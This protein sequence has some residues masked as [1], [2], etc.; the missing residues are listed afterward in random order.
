MPQAHVSTDTSVANVDNMDI[1]KKTALSR[2]DMVYGMHSKYLRYNLWDDEEK[3]VLVP[4]IP[5][6]LA[7]WTKITKP[8]PAVPRSEFRNVEAMKTIKDNPNLFK[9]VTPVNVDRFERL[10]V[11]HSNCAF[12]ELV[13]R[14]LHE[15]FWPWADMQ[16][17][18]YPCMVDESLGMPQREKEG[19]FL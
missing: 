17:G 6:D 1:T 2:I 14:G 5:L 16:Y 13:C 18:V 15:G 8:L 10:L 3:G 11:M 12:M 9:I 19:E 4:K 7:D